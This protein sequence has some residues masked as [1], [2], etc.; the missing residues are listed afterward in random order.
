MDN[1][2]IVSDGSISTLVC[3][4]DKRILK[5]LGKIKLRKEIQYIFSLYNNQVTS[6][7]VIMYSDGW[8]SSHPDFLVPFVDPNDISSWLYEDLALKE[9]QRNESVS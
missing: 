8:L 1:A 7:G 9:R 6:G 4:S 5:L 3:D 2:T